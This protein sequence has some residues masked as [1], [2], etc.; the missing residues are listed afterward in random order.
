MSRNVATVLPAQQTALVLDGGGAQAVVVVRVLGALGWNVVCESGTRSSRSRWTTAT[1]ELPPPAADSARYIDR[2]R[3]TCVEWDVNLVIPSSDL[4]LAYCWQAAGA[5]ATVVGARVLAADRR[6]A[7]VFLDKAT[8]IEASRRHGFGVPETIVAGTAAEIVDAA[9]SLGFPCVI[10]PRRTYQRIGGVMRQLRHVKVSSR[11]EA[12]ATVTRLTGDDGL[13]P[14]AQEYV[15]GRAL[16]VTAVVHDGAVVACSARETFSFFPLGGG[17]S[18]WKRT[19]LPDA[20]GV[21]EA[22]ALLRDCGL[23]GIAEVEYKFSSRGPRFMELGPRIHAWIPLAEASLPGLLAAAI[24]TALGDEVEPLPVHRANVEMRWI[25]GEILRVRSALLGR[26]SAAA[27]ADV[28]RTLW[29]PWKPSML[30]DGIDLSD[31]GPWAPRALNYRRA[32]RRPA[33]TRTAENEAPRTN[34]QKGPNVPSA[35]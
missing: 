31:P 24:H 19:I 5:D 12:L 34:R 4:T 20:P 8:G 13:L 2:L 30:Y 1:V 28:L 14:F 27:R 10:K 22:L 11:D 25:G 3:E 18:V 35:G 26:T 21:Q 32:V 23:E 15:D 33:V 9:Q 17:T 29:P 16:A 6:S 7:E